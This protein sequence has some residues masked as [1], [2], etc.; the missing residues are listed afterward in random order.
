MRGGPRA[1]PQG[2]SCPVVLWILLCLPWLRLRGSHPLRPV[3]PVPFGCHFR[4]RPQS[5]PRHARHG[6]L[7]SSAF[8][9]RYLRNHFCF[10]FLRLL[11]CFSSPGSPPCAMDS[12]MDAWSPSM[13]VPPFRDPWLPGYLLLPTAFRSLSRLSSAPSAKASALC[14]FL[15]NLYSSPRPHM[16]IALHPAAASLAFS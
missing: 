7:G 6:G 5:E 14:P 13:R 4:S 11:R 12:H 9:R 1:F 15:L 8:A 3:F 10:L 2:S 16:R